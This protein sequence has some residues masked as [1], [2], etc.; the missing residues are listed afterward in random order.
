MLPPPLPSG[1]RSRPS[2]AIRGRVPGPFPGGLSDPNRRRRARGDRP[3]SLPEVH[4][5]VARARPI[6]LHPLRRRLRHPQVVRYA[7]DREARAPPHQRAVLARGKSRRHDREADRR[8]GPVPFDP[9][10]KADAHTIQ[11]GSCLLRQSGAATLEP[12]NLPTSDLHSS[13][14]TRVIWDRG[15]SIASRFEGRA[16]MSTASSWTET[17]R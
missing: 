4:E 13:I 7:L 2:A 8:R 12:M 15:I 14:R 9:R 10:Q 1:G 16:T 17:S 5:S 3:D 6:T 11:S